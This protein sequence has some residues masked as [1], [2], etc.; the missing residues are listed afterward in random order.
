[1][2]WS[3][4]ITGMEDVQKMTQFD[5][6][7]TCEWFLPAAQSLSVSSYGLLLAVSR[8]GSCWNS[9][10]MNVCFSPE[11]RHLPGVF[12]SDMNFRKRPIAVSSVVYS[13]KEPPTTLSGIQ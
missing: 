10:L 9:C 5:N 12:F 13:L 11:S 2:N 6:Y 1:M 3:M 4:N 7:R 8:H